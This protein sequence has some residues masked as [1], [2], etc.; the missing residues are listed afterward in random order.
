MGSHSEGPTSVGL[1]TWD[2]GCPWEG[3]RPLT[4]MGPQGWCPAGWFKEPRALRKSKGMA[5][6]RRGMAHFPKEKIPTPHP[7]PR[8]ELVLGERLWK[9][10]GPLRPERHWY[11]SRRLSVAWKD[12]IALNQNKI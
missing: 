4:K 1:G 6:G 9:K 8:A 12:M 3:S 5:S 11:Q 10:E 2:S 7:W